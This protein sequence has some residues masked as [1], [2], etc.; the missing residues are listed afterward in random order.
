LRL[1]I[2]GIE[3]LGRAGEHRSEMQISHYNVVNSQQHGFQPA[4]GNALGNDSKSNRAI[5]GD[6]QLAQANAACN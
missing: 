4:Q 3:V 6:W 5:S 1:K 2:S